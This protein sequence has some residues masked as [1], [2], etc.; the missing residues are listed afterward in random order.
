VAKNDSLDILLT[1]NENFAQH[2]AVCIKSL[3]LNHPN[4]KINVKIASL[5]L[6]VTAKQNLYSMSDDNANINIDIVDFDKTKLDAL[7][8]IGNYTKDIYLRL[9]VDEFF[10][11][12]NIDRVLYLD[13]DTI[14]VD[15]LITLWELPLNDNILAAVD[16]P[17]ST[18]HNRC[19]LPK[20]FN[21][22]NSGVILF[23]IKLW[24]QENCLQQII[25]F[26]HENKE[27]ALNPDQ[28]A[29]NGLFHDRR[30]TLDYTYNAISPFFR[31]K[32]FKS[33]SIEDLSTIQ[34]NVKIV[35]FNGRARPW[36]YG[37]NHPYKNQYLRYLR[38]TPWKKQKLLNKSFKSFIKRHISLLF[39]LDTFVKIP[40][41]LIKGK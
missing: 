32:G 9:W 41:N 39:K 20:E 31:K 12:S 29:L 2:C 27:I 5:E 26:L 34:K 18:S 38:L 11:E 24:K 7:P 17:E 6:T 28:D 22:F 35:H 14:V 40:R 36:I 16:I 19:H 3:Q 37:C 10:Q 21:Y 4:I 33:I 15:S 8:Q 30:I 1:T 13:A 25:T 23:N